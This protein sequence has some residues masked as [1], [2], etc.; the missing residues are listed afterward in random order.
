M[1]ESIILCGLFS[2]VAEVALEAIREVI[3]VKT[4]TSTHI[5][6]IWEHLY[7][8]RRADVFRRLKS[9]ADLYRGYPEQGPLL[10]TLQIHTDTTQSAVS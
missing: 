4:E 3:V 8:R 10:Q 7:T 9:L 1:S 2:R 5:S 6:N